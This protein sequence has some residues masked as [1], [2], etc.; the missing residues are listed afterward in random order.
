MASTPSLQIAAPGVIP[1]V[2]E[3]EHHGEQPLGF[4]GK[5]AVFQVMVA[6]HRVIPASVQR[7]IQPYCFN[8]F[9]RAVNL[10]G[11]PPRQN[12]VSALYAPVL[13][14][15][16]KR[17]DAELRQRTAIHIK[18]P[19]PQLRVMLSQLVHTL[20]RTHQQDARW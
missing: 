14:E 18:Q 4:Q 7:E 5:I 6:H 2:G 9:R 3:G 17:A 1:L 11:R 15:L 19:F 13:L 10:F 16:S 8:P 12:R 20:E